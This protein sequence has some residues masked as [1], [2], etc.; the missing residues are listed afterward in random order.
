MLNITIWL[1]VVFAITGS[2]IL[3]AGETPVNVKFGCDKDTLRWCA[4][5]TTRTFILTID[6]GEMTKTDS[7][8][9]YNFQINYDSN[10][11]VLTDMLTA[12][13]L[14]EN[15]DFKNGGNDT[16]GRFRG[17]AMMMGMTPMTGKLP[18]TAVKGYL[19]ENCY[20]DMDSAKFSLEYMEFTDEFT[21]DSVM[22]NPYS[23]PIRKN[24]NL[25]PSQYLKLRVLNDSVNLSDSAQ[26]LVLYVEKP[27]IDIF[28]ISFKLDFSSLKDYISSDSGFVINV[29]TEKNDIESTSVSE[30]DYVANVTVS[31]NPTFLRGDKIIVNLRQMDS[32]HADY[33]KCRI[34][35]YPGEITESN[36][37]GAYIPDSVKVVTIPPA[38]SVEEQDNSSLYS[39]DGSNLLFKND[40]DNVKIYDIR[41]ANIIDKNNVFSGENLQL[42]NFGSCVYFAILKSNKTTKRILIIK[43]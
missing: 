37:I 28:T 27:D 26:K 1:S 20:E 6:I 35:V 3:T 29:E 8:Y 34:R 30:S 16:L 5:Q 40:Y 24:N 13:T 4:D 32:I 25:S 31:N 11:V 43:N 21:H 19:K 41:G 38:V 2:R 9:G 36:C 33:G 39:F 15:C 14:S 7:L 22:L 10:R 42:G 23:L 12:G 17:T 18:L